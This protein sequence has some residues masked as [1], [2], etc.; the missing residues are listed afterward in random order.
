VEDMTPKEEDLTIFR[1]T[2]V[3]DVT[4][5]EEDLTIFRPP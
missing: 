5:K 4:S 3:E 2:L 1:G